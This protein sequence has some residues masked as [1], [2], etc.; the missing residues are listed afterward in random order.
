MYEMECAEAH[1]IAHRGFKEA[2]RARLVLEG[3]QAV[4]GAGWKT[5]M[6]DPDCKLMK[7]GEPLSGFEAYTDEEKKCIEDVQA[8]A[9]ADAVDAAETKASV[10][11]TAMVGAAVM[12]VLVSAARNY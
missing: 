8:A 2:E 1:A 5:I 6:S 10:K 12:M 3:F 9:P 11:M 4:M 7:P